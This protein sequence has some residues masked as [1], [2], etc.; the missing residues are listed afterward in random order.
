[1]T[2]AVMLKKA[3]EKKKYS[4]NQ[5]CFQ[6]AKRDVWLDRAVLSKLKNGKLPPAKDDLNKVLAEVLDIDPDT[7]RVAAIK[8]TIPDD[9]LEL[10]KKSG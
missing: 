3:I 10:L 7:F 6:L 9:L 5:V 8:E 4:L 1:M 2:Y